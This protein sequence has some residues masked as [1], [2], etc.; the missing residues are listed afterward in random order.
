MQ[1]LVMNIEETRLMQNKIKIQFSCS[2]VPNNCP[3]DC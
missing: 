1:D 2:R 3:Y